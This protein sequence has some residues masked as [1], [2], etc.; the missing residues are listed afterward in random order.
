MMV[1]KF[2]GKFLLV[3]L[4]ATFS[5][6]MIGKGSARAATTKDAENLKVLQ[7]QCGDTSGLYTVSLIYA[8]NL[9]FNKATGKATFDMK[10]TSYRCSPTGKA[11]PNS[12]LKLTSANASIVL[13]A[14][15]SYPVTFY[16]GETIPATGQYG[17]IVKPGFSVTGLTSGKTYSYSYNYNICT[18]TTSCADGSGYIN[19]TTPDAAAIGTFDSAS[20]DTLSGWAFDPDS[21]ATSIQVHLYIDGPAGTGT[22]ISA[23]ATSAVRTDVNNAYSITGVHGFSIAVPAEYRNDV[24]HTVYAYAIGIDSKGELSNSNPNFG[25]KKFGPCPPPN[26][27]PSGSINVSCSAS[28]LVTISSATVKDKEGGTLSIY[29]TKPDTTR[30]TG[31]GNVS[32]NV[33]TNINF[34]SSNTFNGTRD[35][36]KRTISGKVT[37]ADGLSADIS[38]TY[39]C[40]SPPAT[41]SCTLTGFTVESGETFIPQMSI[42]RNTDTYSPDITVVPS[43][44]VNGTTYT[45]DDVTIMVSK[46]TSTQSFRAIT[47]TDAKEYAVT[48]SVKNSRN[49]TTLAT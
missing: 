38:G 1:G 41:V 15:L 17:P 2:S 14:G 40:S 6:L 39:T 3:L 31:S 34:T 42:S 46:P 21:S 43:I 27:A 28:G 16:S 19:I 30:A 23:A 18:F 25:S 45:N 22:I 26:T 37:D 33:S 12:T 5:V 24:E 32:A 10:G 36:V 35:G 20:C 13:P 4:F 49:V 11:A 7:S 47:L 9:V 44:T 29:A 8:D 48:G